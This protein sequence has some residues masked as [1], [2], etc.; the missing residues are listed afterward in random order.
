[1]PS[2]AKKKREQKKKEQ[3]KAKTTGKKA[4]KVIFNGA[5]E[6]GTLYFHE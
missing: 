3:I 5:L 1:M 2:D 6:I 4:D